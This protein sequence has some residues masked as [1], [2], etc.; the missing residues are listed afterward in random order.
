MSSR[1]L[2]D[3]M[4]P[5]CLRLLVVIELAFP[6]SLR[7]KVAILSISSALIIW[8]LASHNSIKNH[9]EAGS[10]GVRLVHDTEFGKPLNTYS[11]CRLT[12][13]FILLLLF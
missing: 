1:W 7:P 13:C 9:F 2:F 8:F 5:C 10:P 4:Q 6:T 3:G 12:T 11:D